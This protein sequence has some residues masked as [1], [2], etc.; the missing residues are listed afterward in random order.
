ML[1]F[2]IPIIAAVAIAI[3]LGA[4]GDGKSKSRGSAARDGQVF[5]MLRRK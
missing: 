2:L 5:Y 4:E 1:I 3:A